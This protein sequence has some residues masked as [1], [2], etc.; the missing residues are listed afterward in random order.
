MGQKQSDKFGEIFQPKAYLGK[1]MR[2][3]YSS[4][5][6]QQLPSKYFGKIILDFEVIVKSIKDTD[7][8]FMNNS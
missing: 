1:Y 5:H 3:K 4:E 8:N 7:K 6:Y 2:E